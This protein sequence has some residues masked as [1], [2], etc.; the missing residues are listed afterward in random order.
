M[1]DPQ[2]P[3]L[4]QRGTPYGGYR[5]RV[6]WDGR[7]I[8]GVSKVG[9]LS[10]TTQVVT[11]RAGGDPA[12]PRRMPGQSEFGPIDLER[13]VTYDTAFL[14]WANKVWDFHTS[15]GEDI[16]LDDFRRDIV[17]EVYNEAGQKVIAYNVHRCWPSELEAMPEL[18]SGGTAVAIQLLRLQ[19]EG[20][21]RDVPGGDG[22]EPGTAP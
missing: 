9:A 11:H 1:S 18:E 19:N 12:V 2:V 20:W 14:A 17:I 8:A 15:G 5:F 16:S 10:R 3:G 13:G 6:K 21:E 7:Y 22:G 4:A